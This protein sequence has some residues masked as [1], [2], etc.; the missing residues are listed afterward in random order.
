MYDHLV[1]FKPFLQDFWLSFSPI[2]CDW[3]QRGQGLSSI[4]L[5]SWLNQ[6]RVKFRV[7]R[8]INRDMWLY[9][10]YLTSN[11][12]WRDV[13]LTGIFG[14]ISSQSL[15]L[16]NAKLGEFWRFSCLFARRISGFGGEI[17]PARA[18]R[19]GIYSRALIWA[20]P[21]TLFCLNI[22][23]IKEIIKYKRF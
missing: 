4:S 2:E 1:D 5:G 21:S 16:I 15:V 8:D 20:L 19:E 10:V 22:K 17:G 23:E 18:R 9:P 6:K 12:A 14:S 13:I 11:Q 7:K 3:W